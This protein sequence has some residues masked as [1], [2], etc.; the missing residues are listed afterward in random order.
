MMNGNT[1]SIYTCF[2]CLKESTDFKI[3]NHCGA[4]IEEVDMANSIVE[5]PIMGCVRID[6]SRN[7]NVVKELVEATV[8]QLIKKYHDEFEIL[9]SDDQVIIECNDISGRRLVAELEP[10][11][12][13]RGFHQLL[14][15]Q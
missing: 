4:A 7:K 1:N 3:C 5:P 15:F 14:S 9:V 10:K 13:D 8:E 6:S 11:L 12:N 2:V